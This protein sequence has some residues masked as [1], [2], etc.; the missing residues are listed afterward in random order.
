MRDDFR[1]TCRLPRLLFCHLVDLSERENWF[2]KRGKLNATRNEGIRLDFLMFTLLAYLGGTATFKGMAE[3]TL[4]S[5][6][7]LRNFFHEFI[8]VMSTK[9]YEIYVVLP[10]TAAEAQRHAAIHAAAGFPGC[11]GSMDATDIRLWSPS[12]AARNVLVGKSGYQAVSFN[13]IVDAACRILYSSGA[14][15]GGINDKTK[16]KD[17]RVI[18]ELRDGKAFVDLEWDLFDADGNV[19]K[20][21]GAW[22]LSGKN[23]CE[24]ISSAR[25]VF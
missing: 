2:P 4:V 3:N 6:S 15:P 5:E 20:C 1:N 17:C 7:T 8:E 13:I 14:F 10:A 18:T 19:T 24:K 11:V 12:Y 23:Q 9:L 21:K 25:L 16:V 22:V